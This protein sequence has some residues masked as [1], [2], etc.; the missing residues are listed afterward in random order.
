MSSSSTPRLFKVKLSS[1][2]VL[3]PLDLERIQ[4]FVLKGK[5]TGNEQAREYPEGEW[6][7]VNQVPE[8]AD[9][10]VQKAQGKLVDPKQKKKSAEAMNETVRLPSNREL[11]K[12]ELLPGATE[13]LPADAELPETQVNR[14]HKD[15]DPSQRGMLDIEI[16]AAGGKAT[17]PSVQIPKDEPKK[18]EPPEEESEDRTQVEGHRVEE[19]TMVDTNPSQQGVLRVQKNEGGVGEGKAISPRHFEQDLV[20]IEDDEGEVV[21]NNAQFEMNPNAQGIDL[22][23]QETIVFQRSP[24]KNAGKPKADRRETIKRVLVGVALLLVVNEILDTAELSGPVIPPPIKPTLPSSIDAKTVDPRMSE[25]YYI[26]G[27]KAYVDDTVIG[28]KQAVEKLQLSAKAD[29]NNV[30]TLAMLASCYLNLIDSSNKDENY[31]TV[32]SKLIDM[33]RAK[34]VDLPET[35][36]ADVEFYLTVNKPEAAVSRIVEYTKT[37][38]AFGLEM[39]YYIAESFFGRGDYQSAA[40]YVS[41]I[42]DNK[43]FSARVFYLRGKIAEAL[44]EKEQALAEYRKG[45]QFNKRHAKSRLAVIRL[46]AEAG[47][48]D[49]AAKSLTFLMNNRGLLSPPELAKAYYIDA[50]YN[51][52]KENWDRALGDMERAVQLVKD[53]HDYMLELYSLRYK[54]GASKKSVQKE[55]RMYFFLG[56]GEKLVKAGNSQDALVQFLQARQSN[57]KSPIPLV[58][59]GDMFLY[60]NNV[61]SARQNYQQAAELAP[62]DIDI[63]SK[64]IHTLILSFDWEEAQKAMDKFRKLPVSQSAIDKAAGDMYARQGR[65]VEAQTFYRKAMARSSIDSEVY[66]AYAKSL[67]GT[68][69]YG[70]APFFFSLAMRFDPLNSEAIIGIAKAVAAAES[71]DRGINL[72]E[73]ELKKGGRARGELLAAIA[74]FQIQKGDFS[75]AQKFVD[76]AM[77]ANPDYAYPWWLQAQIYM[78]KE[79]IDKKAPD[80]ALKAYE[81]YSDRNPSDP[82]GYME[83]YRIYAKRGDF[84]KANEELGKIYAIYPKYPSLHFY[85]GALYSAMGNHQTAVS[86]YMLELKNNPNEFPTIMALGREMVEVGAARDA[87]EQFNK[88]MSI[89]PTS[90]D[91]KQ[92]AGYANFMLKNYPTAIALYQAALVY[93]KAN[94]LIYKRLGVAYRALGDYNNAGAAFRKYLEMEPDAVDRAEFEPY[95]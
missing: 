38:K 73:D 10:L 14:F 68:K 43:A 70:D 85:K 71:I 75:N 65:H 64:Y 63:W 8:I 57:P 48:W 26:E 56:E 93:D 77:Q 22:S 12:T 52:R 13:V 21:R 3:G 59:A 42:P 62:T 54:A 80:K 46:L 7:S 60:L 4:L 6:R 1:G 20:M 66:L 78:N 31:F 30:K 92:M 32:I 95:L 90:A 39:F 15:Q 29:I 35:V 84:E 87:L 23:R 2:R 51:K 19:A 74:E 37:H 76:Q 40:K 45:V 83:R 24:S 91:A 55:A 25:Q 81:S 94:P 86:E 9:L 36:I 33:S 11:A 53:N 28:Y 50:M 44:G 89:A 72:L 34:A 16:T 41:Q 17:L 49:D 61:G 47:K 79:G 58:K 67:M 82:R 69:N 88:A 18:S 27:M 5:I